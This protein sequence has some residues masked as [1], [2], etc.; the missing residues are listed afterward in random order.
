[1]TNPPHWGLDNPYPL[2]YMKTEL[3]CIKWDVRSE[4]ASRPVKQDQ[5]ERFLFTV[6]HSDPFLRKEKVWTPLSL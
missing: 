2:S 1:M 6:L 5:Q 4:I 3:V